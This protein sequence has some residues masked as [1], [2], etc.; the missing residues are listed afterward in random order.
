[1]FHTIVSSKSLFL[2]FRFWGRGNGDPAA[3][4]PPLDASLVMT[5]VFQHLQQTTTSYLYTHF[6]PTVMAMSRRIFAA[7][8]SFVAVCDKGKII[9]VPNQAP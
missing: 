2:K 6:V 9:S 1:M 8:V 7:D 3:P 4:P 5:K